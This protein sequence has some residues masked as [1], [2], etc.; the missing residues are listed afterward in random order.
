MVNSGFFS[1]KKVVNFR[2]FNCHVTVDV[3]ML[4]SCVAEESP[5]AENSQNPWVSQLFLSILIRHLGTC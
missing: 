4:S 1:V 3:A 2:T 5:N